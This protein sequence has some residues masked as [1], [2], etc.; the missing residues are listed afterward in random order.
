MHF[1]KPGQ[2]ALTQDKSIYKV[3]ITNNDISNF[4]MQIKDQA[5]VE[6]NAKLDFFVPLGS[7][8]DGIELVD[9]L[10]SFIGLDIRVPTG[11]LG[12]YKFVKSKWINSGPNNS[13][14]SLEYFVESKLDIWLNYCEI[15]N[16]AHDKI[17]NT[18]LKGFNNEIDQ[19]VM[20]RIVG[21]H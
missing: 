8:V 19:I 5:C 4:F 10:Q 6:K 7:S 2:V 18:V 15:L 12:N 14:P 13:N 20:K 1:E 3:N 9:K 11:Y 21:K 16:D 17:N